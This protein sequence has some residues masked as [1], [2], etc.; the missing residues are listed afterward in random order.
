MPCIVPLIAIAVAFEKEENGFLPFK[1]A[2]I[3]L[4][5]LAAVFLAAALLVLLSPKGASAKWITDLQSANGGVWILFLGIGFAL[6]GAWG[7]RGA[8]LTAQRWMVWHSALLILLTIAA[9]SI[10]GPNSGIDALVAKAPKEN[11]QWIS[12]GNYFQ[13]LPFLTKGRVA[14]VGGAGEL[15]YGENHLAPEVRDRWFIEDGRALTSAAQRMQI[16]HPDR[17]VW[18]LSDIK[19]WLDLAPES[20]LAWEQVGASPK[21]VLLRYVGY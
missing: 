6:I 9:Q 12:H 21:T 16:E 11:V 17:S 14:L 3:E 1:R 19:A 2:G 10:N 15:A 18:A 4:L 8:A 13:A 5:S 7:I 20:Q